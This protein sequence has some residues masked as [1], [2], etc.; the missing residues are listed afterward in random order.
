MPPIVTDSLPDLPA[1][2]VTAF[3]QQADRPQAGRLDEVQ[4]L[5][6]GIGARYQLDGVE[7][8]GYREFI[9]PSDDLFV[10]VVDTTAAIDWSFRFV[11][12]DFL[13]FQFRLEGTSTELHEDQEAIEPDAPF[14][15]VDLHPP[16]MEK[17]VWI[18]SGTR[19]RQISVK[20]KPAFVLRTLGI[21][22]DWLPEPPRA[23]VDGGAAEFFS[24]RM[25]LTSAMRQ[26]CVDML[27]CSFRNALR[28]AFFEAKASE[29]LCL[30]LD[31]LAH[32]DDAKA[33]PVRL[34]DRDIERLREAM[35]ILS[36]NYADPPPVTR[37]ARRIGLNRNK[38]AYGF[39]HIFGL[40]ISQY[41]QS[42]RMDEAY[43]LLKNGRMGVAQAAEAVGY[44]DPGGFAKLFRRHF[45]V[46]P[47]DVLMDGVNR[48]PD[49]PGA[50]GRMA[51]S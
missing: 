12:E 8:T 48:R 24:L 26:A 45:G 14:F 31:A 2:D 25:P 50:P 3:V 36:E 51:Q 42:R 19:F 29:L 17:A 15:G 34:Y 43:A 7:G 9:R 28:R 4:P 38:L 6:D 21:A 1:A 22:P 5:A 35:G 49:G 30:A 37:L 10:I 33:L 23:Y 41:L 11:E 39:K 46:L 13:T 16:G 20:L 44:A 47:K 40:T 32:R 18:P 27:D